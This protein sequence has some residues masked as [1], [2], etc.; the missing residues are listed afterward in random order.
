M[1]TPPL[2]KCNDDTVCS[3]CVKASEKLNDGSASDTCIREDFMNVLGSQHSKYYSL[4]PETLVRCDITCSFP[5]QKQGG[6]LD[7]FWLTILA[8]SLASGAPPVPHPDGRTDAG[9]A[10]ILFRRSLLPRASNKNC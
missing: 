2:A 7:G 8:R 6:C 5:D 10:Y 1:L 9:Y 3:N 4:V